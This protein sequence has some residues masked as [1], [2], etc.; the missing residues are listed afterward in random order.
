MSSKNVNLAEC[1]SPIL[2]QSSAEVVSECAERQY[3][4]TLVI[5]TV[6]LLLVVVLI[7]VISGS[8]WCG[9][10]SGTGVVVLSILLWMFATQFVVG[11]A[12]SKFDSYRLQREAMV[13]QGMSNEEA[14]AQQQQDNRTLMQSRSREKSARIQADWNFR[15]SN[16]Y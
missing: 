6:I 15:R 1:L 8:P 10:G 11:S 14:Y 12:V 3:K 7:S 4:K 2:D 5:S 13:K 16:W 9:V